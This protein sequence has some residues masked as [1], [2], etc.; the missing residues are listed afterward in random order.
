[1][2]FLSCMYIEYINILNI[3]NSNYI[4]FEIK[5]YCKYSVSIKNFLFNIL[6]SK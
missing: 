4:T 3:K 6:T 2:T 5:Q 1:M